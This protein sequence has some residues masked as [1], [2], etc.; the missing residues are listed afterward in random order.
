MAPGRVYS[1]TAP[2]DPA[3]LLP[4]DLLPSLLANFHAPIRFAAGYGSGVFPQKSYAPDARPMLDLILGVTHPEHWHSLNLRQHPGHYS[5]LRRLGSWSVARVQSMAAGV[6][7]NTHVEIDGWKIKY[8]VVG[9]DK[10]ERDLDGWE[11]FYLAGRFQKPVWIAH[12]AKGGR[13]F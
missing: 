4:P 10:L 8:G 9:M 2:T 11:T 12:E 6:Y 3:S 7:Y 5:G 13:K 1:T